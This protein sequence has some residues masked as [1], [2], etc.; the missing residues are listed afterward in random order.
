MSEL[1]VLSIVVGSI[2]GIALLIFMQIARNKRKWELLKKNT[3]ELQSE[4]I[5]ELQVTTHLSERKIRGLYYRY[6]ELD[7]DDSGTITAAEFCTMKEMAVNPLSYRIFDAFD[8]NNDGHLDFKEF[9][10]LVST[11][12]PSGNKQD[13]LEALFNI[14]DVDG[15][16]RI[17]KNDLKYVLELVTIR[18]KTEDEKKGI[19]KSKKGK[20]EEELEEEDRLLAEEKDKNWDDYIRTII[21]RIMFESSSHPMSTSLSAE[22]FSKAISESRIDFQEKM[23]MEFEHV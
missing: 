22:D 18:P 1:F 15:D 9:I 5:L 8:K 23:N 19:T 17:N 10:D 13:K 4:D 20:T 14:Y 2:G 16:G 3:E 6:K 21:N 11:M 12:A 7:S